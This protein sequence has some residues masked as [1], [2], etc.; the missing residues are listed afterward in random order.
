MTPMT[1]PINTAASLA[2][3]FMREAMISPF[4]A[5]TVPRG[6]NSRLNTCPAILTIAEPPHSL[7]FERNTKGYLITDY[8]QPRNDGTNQE[9]YGCF[10]GV[11]D[12]AQQGP[13]SKGPQ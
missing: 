13:V 1:T 4:A 5:R 2:N 3:R 9:H 7:Q 12:G 11:D 6:G 10:C 8:P